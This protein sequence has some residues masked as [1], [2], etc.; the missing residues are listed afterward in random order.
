MFFYVKVICRLVQL[1]CF[2]C[3]GMLPLLMLGCLGIDCFLPSFSSWSHSIG[4]YWGIYWHVFLFLLLTVR[5]QVILSVSDLSNYVYQSRDGNVHPK[6]ATCYKILFCDG[7]ALCQSFSWFLGLL[8]SYPEDQWH[9]VSP[10]NLI[11]ELAVKFCFQP[12]VYHFIRLAVRCK[13]MIHPH[14]FWLRY[15]PVHLQTSQLL[16]HPHL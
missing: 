9:W 8:P 6:G 4:S 12:L 11:Q 5:D 15:A 1:H 14:S 7:V 2:R 10:P 16:S 3:S 13:L